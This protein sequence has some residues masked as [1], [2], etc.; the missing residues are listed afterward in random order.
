MASTEV[1]EMDLL[2]EAL[3]KA[4]HICC[5]TNFACVATEY[6]VHVSAD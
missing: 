5:G 4:S 6:H 2:A 1:S 3:S